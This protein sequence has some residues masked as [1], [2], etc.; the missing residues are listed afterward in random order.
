MG[1]VIISRRASTI[2]Q[3]KLE[4]KKKYTKEM[5]RIERYLQE[6]EYKQNQTMN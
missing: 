3:L 1:C 2:I 6:E 4:C 5:K